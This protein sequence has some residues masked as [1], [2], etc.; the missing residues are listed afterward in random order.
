MRARSLKAWVEQEGIGEAVIYQ[1]LESTHVLYRFGV[2]LYNFIQQRAPI[3]HQ[4]YFNYL[5]AAGMFKSA[6]RI[7][8]KKKFSEVLKKEKPNVIVSVHGSLNHGFFE[9]AREVLG[10][11]KVACVTYCGELFGGYGFSKHWVNPQADLF[12]GATEETRKAAVRLGMPRTRAW[13]GGFLLN[14]RFWEKTLGKSARDAWVREQFGLDP[15]QFLL[16]LGTG[17]TGANNHLALLKELH[18]ARLDIQVVALCGR[19]EASMKKIRRW[20]KQHPELP[21]RAMGYTNAMA[22]ILHSA[23]AL[24]ARPGTGSTSE[25]ILAGCPIIFNRIGGVMPQEWITIK[26][27]RKRGMAR[28]I[29]KPSDLPR[30][31]KDLARH[32]Q[33]WEKTQQFMRQLHPRKTPRDILKKLQQLCSA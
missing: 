23:S 15:H 2:E 14:P 32:S 8:G 13:T 7:L 6:R 11:D 28:V 12:I 9:M 24:V 5:E 1:A 19:N 29:K 3:L 27:F 18:R 31:V 33:R 17:A 20:A 30:I 26:Y 16:V 25:A 4:V 22:R 10:K 21:T